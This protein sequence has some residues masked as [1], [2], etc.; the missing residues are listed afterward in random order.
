VLAL[1][2]LL[3]CGAAAEADFTIMPLGASNTEGLANGYTGEFIPGG[4]R[5]RL[6]SD[7][8]SAGY[9]FTFVGTQTSN[10][11]PTLR[12]AGQDHH[13][14]HSGYRIDQVVKNLDGNDGSP[15]NNGGFW[16]HKPAPPSIV[17]LCIGGADILQGSSPS[18]TAQGLDNLIGRILADSPTSLLLVASY[19]ASKDAR[20]NQALQHYNA[21]I[22]NVIVPK[23]A[24]LGNRVIFVDQH[25]NFVDA[26]GNIIHIGPD[27]IHP[28]QTGYDLMGDTW[29]AALQ[30][31]IPHPIPVLGCSTDVIS[32]KDPSVRLAQP[33][34]ASTFAW[35]E[36]GA[37]DDTGVQHN[38]GL[39]AGVSFVSA[40]G[41]Q[42]TYQLQLAHAN[43]VLQLGAGQTGS[44]TLTTPAVYSTL[45]VIA[46]SG[47]GTPASVG[48]GTIH[49]ADGSTQAFTYNCFDW[50]NG[51]GGLHPEAVLA[52]P[53]GRADVGPNGT[54]FTY[55]QDCDFQIYETAIG[56]DASHA[57]IAMVSIDFSGAPDAFLSNIFGVSGQ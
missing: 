42:A 31:A 30:Q 20:L 8:Q 51:H 55:N 54:A 4:Y 43:N 2:I 46:S 24:G 13:E 10:P 6:Y 17:L 26:N 18:A 32:D 34:S 7:L 37:V 41:S 16:F 53:I 45:Y 12:Q 19:P 50:C 22:R 39:P 33:L 52:G 49:F 56:L 11:T 44:L 23:Y 1:A 21:Q 47:D 9:S 14:G 27:G 25:P 29:A 38:D 57:G 40:T 48:G 3:F 15:G 35:F 5:A 36:A 28:D